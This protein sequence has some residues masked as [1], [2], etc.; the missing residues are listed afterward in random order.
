MALVVNASSVPLTFKST[1]KLAEVDVS[2]SRAGSAPG[3]PVLLV[4]EPEET[5]GC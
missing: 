5:L 3:A 4:L 2:A 1:G